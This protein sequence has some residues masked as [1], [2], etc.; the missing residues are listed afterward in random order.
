MLPGTGRVPGRGVIGLAGIGVA[1]RVAGIVR[2][3]AVEA[4]GRIRSG[5]ALDMFEE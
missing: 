3:P 4:A 5:V 1:A 2:F